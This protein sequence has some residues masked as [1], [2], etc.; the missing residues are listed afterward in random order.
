MLKNVIKWL[1]LPWFYTVK[2]NINFKKRD[3]INYKKNLMN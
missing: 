2:I 1:K 3:Q